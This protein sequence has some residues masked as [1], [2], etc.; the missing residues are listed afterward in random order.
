MNRRDLLVSTLSAIGIF[1]LGESV[2]ASQRVTEN[3]MFE[4]NPMPAAEYL[5]ILEGIEHIPALYTFYSFMHPDSQAIV[6]RSTII[7][8]YQNDFQPL[9]PQPAIATGV[10]YPDQWV[11][12][13]NGRAYSDVAEVSYTQ[14][15]ANGS[16]TN[17]VVR[18]CWHNGQWNWFFGRDQAWVE[19]Q[20]ARFSQKDHTAQVGVAPYGFDSLDSLQRTFVDRLPQTLRDSN[21]G[22]N[23][24]LTPQV[25]SYDPQ[26]LFST[27]SWLAWESNHRDDI[28]PLGYFGE[29][30]ILGVTD[31]SAALDAIATE[32]QELPPLQ[33][34]GWNAMPSRGPAWIYLGI[35]QNDM[36]GFVN[37]LFLVQ[38][39]RYV[40]VSVRDINN[41]EVISASID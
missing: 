10:A 3:V 2:T 1:G 20:N 21:T 35:F 34:H 4:S 24:T 18:L 41:F 32:F 16:V 12:S 33:F 39:G 37:S 23:H 6:P 28:V 14:S 29:G 17:D 22:R 15:F 11:W 40:H 8:W 26:T 7:G 5:S 38:D 30:T 31:D 36:V 25:N 13:V 27:E 9:G 19:E